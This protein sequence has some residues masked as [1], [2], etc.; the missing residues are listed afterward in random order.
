MCCRVPPYT[1]FEAADGAS[2]YPRQT[3][4]K[5]IRWP[6]VAAAGDGELARDRGEDNLHL[7]AEPD[8]GVLDESLALPALF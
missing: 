4:A 1:A 6:L 8:Q 5:F 7:I 3:H 2:A